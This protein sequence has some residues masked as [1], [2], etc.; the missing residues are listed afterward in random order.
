MIKVENGMPE[1][2]GDIE[3]IM[4]DF[5]TIN[6]AVRN[7]LK[8]IGLSEDER[9]KTMISILFET[10]DHEQDGIIVKHERKLK[11]QEEERPC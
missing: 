2:R 8:K 11:D 1:I 10:A 7:V 9:N 3:T 4:S 6:V 5:F